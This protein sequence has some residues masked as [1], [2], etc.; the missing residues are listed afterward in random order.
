MLDLLTVDHAEDLERSEIEVCI[1][2]QADW[3]KGIHRLGRQKRGIQVALEHISALAAYR[4][5]CIG[6]PRRFTRPHGSAQGPTWQV[7]R[8]SSASLASHGTV[9]LPGLAWYPWRD[10][11]ARHT[12]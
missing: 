10:S 3:S 4:T 7:F 12:V 2:D 5:T 1:D 6:Q 9:M 11:N 8:L